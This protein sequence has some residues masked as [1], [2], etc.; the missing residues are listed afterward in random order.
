MIRERRSWFVER[1]YEVVFVFPYA[2]LCRVI[3]SHCD[4]LLLAPQDFMSG[5]AV[6]L[7]RHSDQL[8]PDVPTVETECD[9]NLLRLLT[10]KGRNGGIECPTRCGNQAWSDQSESE[11]ESICERIELL[12]AK[13][14]QLLWFNNSFDVFEMVCLVKDRWL[15]GRGGAVVWRQVCESVFW[16]REFRTL[17]RPRLSTEVLPS[18]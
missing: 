4:H 10:R 18:R 17:S 7:G 13:T 2:K 6:C 15:V 14:A 3:T 8:R 1:G 16:T 12:D 11:S 9:G 5:P